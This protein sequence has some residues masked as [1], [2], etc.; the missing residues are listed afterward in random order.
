MDTLLINEIENICVCNPKKRFMV[1]NG[2]DGWSYGSPMNPKLIIFAAAINLLEIII[3]NGPDSSINKDSIKGKLLSD[4]PHFIYAE[5]NDP[6]FVKTENN[7]ILSFIELDC[8]SF[9]IKNP[10]LK[11]YEFMV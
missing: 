10:D 5:N 9:T 1:H 11:E 6:L 2:F 3:E 7:K 8:C 4:F